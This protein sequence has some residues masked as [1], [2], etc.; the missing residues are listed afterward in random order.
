MIRAIVLNMPQMPQCLCLRHWSFLSTAPPYLT[1]CALCTGVV[2]VVGHIV[3]INDC[4]GN[5][6][7][8]GWCYVVLVGVYGVL[9]QDEDNNTSRP[10]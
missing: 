10:F 6:C 8:L 9:D 7:G 1:M 2:R 4:F 3:T 5:S